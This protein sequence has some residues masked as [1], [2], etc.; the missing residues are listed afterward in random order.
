MTTTNASGFKLPNETLTLEQTYRLTCWLTAM[1]PIFGTLD[2]RSIAAQ[3][4]DALEFMVTV[5][6]VRSLGDML[7]NVL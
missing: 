2:Y 3:A 7:Q 6:N 5:D 4:N 1:W